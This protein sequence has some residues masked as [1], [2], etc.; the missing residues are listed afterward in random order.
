M[1]RAAND[2]YKSTL[3]AQLGKDSPVTVR[4]ILD[5]SGP[6][7]CEVYG[8][9]EAHEDSGDKGRGNVHQKIE[10]KRFICAEIPAFDV[11]ENLTIYFPDTDETFTVSRP[12]LDENGAQV[13][14]VY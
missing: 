8:W 4:A 13:L 14:W 2:I 5:P 7:E 9:F 12:D 1:T 6:E 3:A 10:M 11:Y